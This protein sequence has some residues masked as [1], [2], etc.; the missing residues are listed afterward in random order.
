MSTI[1]TP[2]YKDTV[3]RLLFNSK[4]ELLSLYN[5]LN[6]T[7]YTNEDDLT[8]NTLGDSAFIKVKNDVSFI[9]NFELNI[10]E[11][12]STLC[13]NM[14]LRD[15]F[16]VAKLLKKITAEDDL[17]SS[18]AI[19]IPAP[20]F[21]VFYNG[22]DPMPDKKI[23]RLSEQFEKPVAE[24]DL[25]LTVTMLNIN[26][27]HNPDIMKVCTA[28]KEYSIFVSTVRQYTKEIPK[29][30]EDRDAAVKEAITKAIDKCIE[31]GILSEFL[32]QHRSKVV[33]VCMWDYNEE[34][35][36]KTM[37]KES[38][39]EGYDTGYGSASIDIY[40]NMISNGYSKEEAMKLTGVTEKQLANAVRG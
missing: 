7:S 22:T 2:K 23:Y 29:D 10:F 32:T 25:E 27:G 17:Y 36:S 5:A 6:G 30:A 18:K 12:Q 28:L 37:K 15:L 19:R 14:P 3:F 24:P 33:E 9:F 16:Y 21:Y 11:H 8:I 34:L 26:E 39:D 35:H 40:D 4:K 1:E 20:R 13:P 38:F 31:D